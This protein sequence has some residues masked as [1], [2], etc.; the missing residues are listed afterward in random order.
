M[1]WIPADQSTTKRARAFTFLHFKVW[2]VRSFQKRDNVPFCRVR[3]HYTDLKKD[4]RRRLEAAHQLPAHHLPGAFRERSADSDPPGCKLCNREERTSGG[5]LE[6][7]PRPC[8]Q[9][10]GLA[11]ACYYGC[12]ASDGAKSGP[13]W[14]RGGRMYSFAWIAADVLGAIKGQHGEGSKEKGAATIY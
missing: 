4:F 12:Y 8:P 1:L 7:V 14:W 9:F 5:R 3:F 13:H 10:R 2:F 6:N 11:S